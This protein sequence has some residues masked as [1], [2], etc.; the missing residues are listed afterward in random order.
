MPNKWDY[1]AV[2]RILTHPKYI[3]SIVFNQSSQRLKT[4]KVFHSA[5]KWI[6]KPNCFEG[7]VPVDWFERAAAKLRNRTVN[8]SNEQ[9][10]SELGISS[11][12]RADSR[13]PSFWAEKEQHPLRPIATALA[14]CARAMS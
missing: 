8:R 3:G 5:E 14:V 7:L 10:I 9:L 2:H 12:R 13:F 1:A 4:A 11:R 6:V